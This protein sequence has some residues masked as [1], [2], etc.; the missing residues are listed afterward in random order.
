MR[1]EIYFVCQLKYSNKLNKL[2]MDNFCYRKPMNGTKNY[3]A[4]KKQYWLG[5]VSRA[6]MI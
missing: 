5:T 6:V 3:I 4:Q 1:A 2:N